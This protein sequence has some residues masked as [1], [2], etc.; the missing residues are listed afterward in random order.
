[1][2]GDAGSWLNTRFALRG[3]VQM[4]SAADKVTR[5]DGSRQFYARLPAAS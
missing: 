4:Q 3:R 2:I 1:M 5:P